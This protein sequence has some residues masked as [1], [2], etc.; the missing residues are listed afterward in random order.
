MRALK[1]TSLEKQIFV[2]RALLSM[3]MVILASLVLLYRFFDLQVLRY[4]D[5]RTQAENNRIRERPLPPNRGLIYDRHGVVLAE[6]RLTHRLEL[7]EERSGGKL[8]ESLAQL[9]QMIAI[10]D[11]EMERFEQELNS[12]RA[13]ESVIVKYKLSESEV[14]RFEV[15]RMRFPGFEVRPYLLRQYPQGELL[16]HVVGY[17]GRMDEND[18]ERAIAEGSS[19]RNYAQTSHFGKTGI[20]AFYELELHGST[21]SERVETNAEGRAI[22]QLSQSPPISGVNLL[23][24]IDLALQRAATEALDGRPG[25]IVVLDVDTGEILALVSAPSYDGNLFVS[26]ISSLAFKALLEAPTRPLYNRAIQGGYA[27]GSTIKPFVGLAGL[28]L[29]LR[30]A[31]SRTLSTGQYALAGQRQVY[32]DWK[33]GGHGYVNLHEALAQSVNTYFYVLGVEMGIDRMST[34]L[35]NFGFGIQ[36]GIDLRGEISGILPSRSFKRERYQQNWYPGETV[37]SAI[38]Q[39]Y[40]L[41]SPLQLAV[42]TAAL[43]N[44]GKLL[45][46]RLLH[47]RKRS[48][49][50]EPV[51]LPTTLTRQIPVDAAH[52]R[53]VHEGMVA[54]LHGP[55]GTAR[56]TG[57]NLSYQIAGKTGTAQTVGARNRQSESNN[58]SF[59]HQ[60]L[61]M[62]FAPADAPEIALALVIEHGGSGS[63]AAAPVAR[64]VFDAYLR[65]TQSGQ[66]Q[67]EPA[68]ATPAENE[69]SQALENIDEAELTPPIESVDQNL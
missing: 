69:D 26:G 67:A 52:L 11:D 28:E 38:G 47:A 6:N 22:R 3:A 13:F 15:E 35:A 2:Q 24:S 1:D 33:V 12:H 50:G 61:F 40:H 45:R 9:R 36:A 43:A 51:L 60:A 57:M 27:P 66:P 68:P 34:Y 39:G 31:E 18:L 46:P 41:V 42:A 7:I 19:A 4:Q 8:R 17:V 53:T 25:A 32:R 44:G 37:I 21:G 30:S 59:E 10:S 64:K 56:A 29:G 14:A 5:F 48:L 23:L 49:E 63:R 55:T 62:G 65:N 20:E 16:A 54:V 58:L